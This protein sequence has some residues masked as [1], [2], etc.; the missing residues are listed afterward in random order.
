MPEGRA[1]DGDAPGGGVPSGRQ[2]SV[3]AVVHRQRKLHAA[4]AAAHHRNLRVGP[5]G[6]M[7]CL[8]RLH[9][10][11]QQHQADHSHVCILSTA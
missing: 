6:S 3:Q 7:Q 4:R 9:G 8:V 2:L 5:C 10:L 1:L 11:K